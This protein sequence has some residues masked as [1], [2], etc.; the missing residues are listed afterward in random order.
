MTRSGLNDLEFGIRLRYE[1]RRGFAPYYMGVSLDRSFGETATFILGEGAL[2]VRS[3]SFWGCDCGYDCQR[4]K[5]SISF[6]PVPCAKLL[7]ASSPTA[8]HAVKAT[9]H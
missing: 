3:D 4:L 7:E 8:A 2:P 9:T 5:P 6:L 1:I